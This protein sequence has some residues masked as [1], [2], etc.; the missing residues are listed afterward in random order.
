MSIIV[1][2]NKIIVGIDNFANQTSYDRP[3]EKNP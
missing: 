2:A 1:I 3:K